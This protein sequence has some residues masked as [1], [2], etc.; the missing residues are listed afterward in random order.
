MAL[1]RRFVRA[2][3]NVFVV[4]A[5]T[6]PATIAVLRTRR[7]RSASNSMS[8]TYDATG[9]PTKHSDC[10]RP[11][12]AAWGTSAIPRP[13]WPP[14]RNVGCVAVATDLLALTILRPPGEFGADIAVGSAQRFGV[15]MGMGVPMRVS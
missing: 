8:A 14:P 12:P 13:S 3:S 7:N 15:P 5:D 11:T 2:P 6:H 9:C 10:S 1:A 4:D